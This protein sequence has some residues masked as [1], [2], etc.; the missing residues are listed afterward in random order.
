MQCCLQHR[1]ATRISGT[2]ETKST[3]WRL[4]HAPT[5]T[6]TGRDDPNL[7]DLASQEV[8]IAKQRPAMAETPPWASGLGRMPLS[9]EAARCLQ[10]GVLVIQC[11]SVKTGDTR[12]MTNTGLTSTAH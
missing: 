5:V 3:A 7:G 12:D 1:S 8:S 10:W 6:A 11:H 2:T 9:P 4:A